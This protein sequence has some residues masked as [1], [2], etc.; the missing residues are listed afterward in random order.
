MT[1]SLTMI[2]KNLFVRGTLPLFVLLLSGCA[3]QTDAPASNA[4][5]AWPSPQQ[6]ANGTSPVDPVASRLTIWLKLVGPEHGTAQQYADFLQTR[7]VWPRWQ[8]LKLRMQ[9]AL[10]AET[11]SAVLN[12]LCADQTLTYGPALAQCSSLAVGA[13]PRLLS[14]LETEA[15]QAWMNGNDAASASTVI[16]T[17]FPHAITPEAS[18][19]RFE[20]EEKAGLLSAARQTIPYLSAQRQALAQARLAF[21][22]GDS[23]AETKL[24]SLSAAD[25]ADP[26]LTLNRMKWLRGQ[27]RFDDA[28]ALWK[29]AGFEAEAATRSPAFWRE[30][31][32]LARDFLQSNR[33][34]D[35]YLLASDTVVSGT[36]HLDAAFLSG[37]ISLQKQNNPD[38]A[39]PFFKQL[40]ESSAL[41]TKSR[42]YYWLGRARLAAHD[43]ASAQ[44]DFGRAASYPGTFYGQMA[45]A[46]LV[47][48]ND[49]LRDPSKI[50]DDVSR[51]LKTERDPGTDTAE[52]VRLSGSDLAQAAQILVSWGDRPHARDFL[53]LLQ[54]QIVTQTDRLA[55]SNL[56]LRLNLPD[57]AVAVARQEGSKGIFLLRSGWPMPYTAPDN[58]LPKGLVLGLM[59]Q[60]SSFNSDAISSSNAIGLMQ[61]KPSTAGDMVRQAG[62]PSSAATA[63]GLHDPDNN[64]RLGTAYLTHLQDRFGSVVPYLAAAYNGG[65]TRLS[66][67]LTS[68]GDPGR[69]GGSQSDMIDWIETIP[70]SETRNYVQRVWENMII[71]AALGQKT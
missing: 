18:W 60:E 7:P 42:G 46:E 1:H 59:R 56:A 38:K 53:A 41:I 62:V 24:A 27:Q 63:S 49:F 45:A 52:S 5:P 50:P 33:I 6:A 40:A 28:L 37:W 67:W 57:I 44:A 25:S 9:Q 48:T 4:E 71:Y 69:N 35:A 61:L 2:V 31:D 8:L 17:T 70:F 10:A 16:V 30:R 36:N 34:D 3:T 64:M 20:R 39:E 54:Q 55:L 22:S 15:R 68:A 65:P 32:A 26:W 47:G 43:Q 21:R 12:K 51:R 29:S 23:A 19:L 13:N 11:D 58:S 66:R 14:R